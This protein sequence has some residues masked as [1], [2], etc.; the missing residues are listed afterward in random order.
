M[1]QNPF[2]PPPESQR[3]PQAVRAMLDTGALL[4]DVREI[5]EFSEIRIPEAKSLPASEIIGR[6]QEIPTDRDVIL[7]CRSGHRSGLAVNMLRNAGYQN[8]YNLDGGIRAWFVAGFPVETTSVSL[9]ASPKFALF[10]E[11]GVREASQ[12]MAQ[13]ATMVDVRE[14]DEFSHGHVLGAINIPL[15]EIGNSLIRL[16]EYDSL[17]LLCDV[18]IRSDV[19]AFYLVDQGFE[20]VANV[21]QGVT[22]WR[23]LNL[24][25]ENPEPSSN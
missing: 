7:H 25:W 18:G 8:A 23:R 13:G 12:R 6:W 5:G 2:L 20:R 11:I 14:Q 17:I 9:A 19:A 10:E 4:L 16:R 24:P 22:G 21:K 1:L 3:G 15:D